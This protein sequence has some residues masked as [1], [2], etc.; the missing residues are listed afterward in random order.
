[1]KKLNNQ[2]EAGR[3]MMEML[4]VLAVIAVLSIAGIAAYKTAMDKHR[5]NEL[6]NKAN[7]CAA[8]IA[9]QVASGK[10]G[11]ALSVAELGD[12]NWSVT[13]GGLTKQF[14]IVGPAVDK[15]VCKQVVNTIGTEN[16]IKKVLSGTVDVSG[17]A[18]KCDDA[19]ITFVYNDDLSKENVNNAVPDPCAGITCTGEGEVCDDGLCV[20]PS[21]TNGCSKNSDCDEWCANQSGAAACFCNIGGY[22]AH[23]GYCEKITDTEKA[24]KHKTW[25]MS[26]WSA[27]NFCKAV[28]G[29]MP[30]KES[31]CNGNSCDTEKERYYWLSDCY[32]SGANCEC[33]DSSPHALGVW[34]GGVSHANRESQDDF[35]PL[36]E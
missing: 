11:T 27:R 3:S 12:N 1:M 34:E 7:K 26:W 24:Q 31:A 16:V 18:S 23:I 32:C 8:I 33:D 13:T 4:G 9:M 28:G 10:S 21:D 19:A 14:G 22:S 35:S 30:S 6:L 17:D 25:D 36:C 20:K 15:D 29:T 2:N 5:S